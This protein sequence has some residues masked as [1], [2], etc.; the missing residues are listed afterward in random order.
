MGSVDDQ[1]EW[2]DD[3]HVLYALSE[4]GVAAGLPA[5][6]MAPADGTGSPTLFVRDAES[7]SVV[8]REPVGRGR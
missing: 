3:H 7:P 1:I 5:I 8:P 4:R 6:W 2:L